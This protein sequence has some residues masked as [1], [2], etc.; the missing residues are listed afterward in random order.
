[1][2]P[3]WSNNWG[4]LT[5]INLLTVGPNLPIASREGANISHVYH[6][7]SKP[8]KESALVAAEAIN[9]GNR[10]RAGGGKQLLIWL[11][12]ALIV[13]KVRKV[14]IIEIIWGC[15]IKIGKNSSIPILWTCL[16][17]SGQV[18]RVYCWVWVARAIEI[19]QPTDECA[20]LSSSKCVSTCE[21]YQTLWIKSVTT[22][23][24]ETFKW[25]FFIL[26]FWKTTLTVLNFFFF[27]IFQ[28]YS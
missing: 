17:Q 26:F 18:W 28:S 9:N 21:S 27:I 2:L 14:A 25:P 5:S 10:G 8:F 23:E 4:S 11:E 6:G 7:L 15:G 13:L 16:L 20:T 1:M 24:K 19:V 3:K 22:A 12:K